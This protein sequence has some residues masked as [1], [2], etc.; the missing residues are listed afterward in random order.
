MPVLLPKKTE[1]YKGKKQLSSDRNCS[2]E[3]GAGPRWGFRKKIS[4]NFW[5]SNVFKPTKLLTIA[6]KNYIHGLIGANT[7]FES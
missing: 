3:P 5:L 2:L 4:S 7:R 6:L 1:F